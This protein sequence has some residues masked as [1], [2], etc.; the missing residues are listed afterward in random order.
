MIATK[1]GFTLVGWLNQDTNTN[2]TIYYV[3][4]SITVES[5]TILY[6]VWTANSDN[7]GSVQRLVPP[8]AGGIAKMFERIG[9]G[10]ASF[11]ESNPFGAVLSMVAILAVGILLIEIV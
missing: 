3:G 6:A 2:G 5:D 4:E 7:D 10:L 9:S 8:L 1:E 11:V